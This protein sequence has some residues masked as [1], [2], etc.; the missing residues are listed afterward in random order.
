[1]KYK[2]IQGL[3]WDV[4]NNQASVTVSAFSAEQARE[5]ASLIDRVLTDPNIVNR[6]PPV[7]AAP[8]EPTPA[9]PVD[10]P[11]LEEPEEK[12]PETYGPGPLVLLPGD[13]LLTGEVVKEVHPRGEWLYVVTEGDFKIKLDMDGNEVARRDPQGKE[14]PVAP[15]DDLPDWAYDNPTLTLGD[16][17]PTL[18]EAVSILEGLSLDEMVARL[19]APDVALSPSNPPPDRLRERVQRTRVLLGMEAGK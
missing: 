9:A 17:A 15:G 16:G 10:T 1:M 4:L 13:R 12:P 19:S 6:P 7:E 5:I 2:T 11:T 14:I 3:T 8:V 18:M